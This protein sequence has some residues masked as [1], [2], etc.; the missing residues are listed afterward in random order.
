MSSQLDDIGCTEDEHNFWRQIWNPQLKRWSL[1]AVSGTICQIPEDSVVAVALGG[2][3]FPV[4]GFADGENSRA[5]AAGYFAPS[6][7]E[8]LSYLLDWF[9]YS[10]S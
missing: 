6:M 5:C 9:H 10:F 1:H 7:V 3:V 4:F 8:M 2:I